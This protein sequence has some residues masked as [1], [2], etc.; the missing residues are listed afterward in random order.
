MSGRTIVI[1]LDSVGIG[2]APD[3]LEF[4]DLGANTLGNIASNCAKNPEISYFDLT[5][6]V[7]PMVTPQ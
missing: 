6:A 5:A 2:G 7:A 3:A 1:I 4:G